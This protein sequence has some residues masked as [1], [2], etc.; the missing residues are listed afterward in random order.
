MGRESA[1]ENGGMETERLWGAKNVCERETEKR[2][3]AVGQ[4]ERERERGVGLR[5]SL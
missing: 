3:C 4:R 5:E 2:P 1:R